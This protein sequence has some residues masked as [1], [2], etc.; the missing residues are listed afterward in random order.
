MHTDSAE[1]V[2]IGGGVT[3]LSSGWWLAKAG[4][5]TIVLDKGV[6][7]YEASSRNGGGVATRAAEPPVAPLGAESLRLWPTLHEDLGYPTEFRPGTIRVAMDEREFALMRASVFEG[8]GMADDAE[9]IDT[10][11]IRELFPIINPEVPGGMYSGVY[12]QANPQRTVQAYAWAFQ[13][14]GGRIHQHTTV[15]G[16]TV[17][18]GKVTA[19]ETDRGTFGAGFVVDSAGP[20][21]ALIAEMAGVFV[22]V[23]PARVEIVVTAPIEFMWRGGVSGNGLYGRQT[24]RGNLAYGGGKQE[25]IDVDLHSPDKPNTPLIRNVAR[26]LAEMFSGAADV[27]LIRSW[28]GVV[29][30]APDHYPIIE[31]TDSPSNFMVASVSGHGFGL[32]PATGKV[33]QELITSG[34]TSVDISGLSMG[35]FGDVGPGWREERGW[36]PATE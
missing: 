11:E 19:V 15:T 13:D 29:E 2:I 1:V 10:Q 31:M 5:D 35:R 28:G 36:T 30:Q 4:V 23:A 34:E 6:I 9:E 22:P 20:Q 26:R 21:T 12:G 8:E 24:L 16:L 33:I 25:W 32:S 27:P 17:E 18:G 14:H 3:G 7:G